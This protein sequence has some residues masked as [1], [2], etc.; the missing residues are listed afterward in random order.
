[1]GKQIGKQSTNQLVAI[2]G[3]VKLA[4]EDEANLGFKESKNRETYFWARS[5]KNVL[6]FFG[7]RYDELYPCRR[8]HTLLGQVY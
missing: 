6:Q 2:G 1:L 8:Y 4:G 7:R 5:K 3:F